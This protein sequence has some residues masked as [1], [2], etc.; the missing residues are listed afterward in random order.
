MF[1]PRHLEPKNVDRPECNASRCSAYERQSGTTRRQQW[2]TIRKGKGGSSK[3][4]KGG[5]GK[6]REEK[7][8]S[9][10]NGECRNCQKKGHKKADCRKMKADI[11]AGRCDK[12]GKP[13]GVNAL[14]A[15]GSTQLSPQESH[16]PSLTSTI[17][18]TGGADVLQSDASPCKNLVHQH[19]H[20][21]PED[22]YGW[23]L[24]RSRIRVAGFWIRLD[25]LSN[26]LC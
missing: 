9:K 14:T 26:L 11:D 2:L 24:G 17:P 21:G 6:E 22:S 16:A 7:A 15:A 20:A 19:D 12:S 23:K 10:F 5:K 18:P 8:A 1:P 4:E 13:K 3:S 25:I